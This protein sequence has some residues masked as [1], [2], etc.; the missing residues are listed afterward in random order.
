[1][2]RR[3]GLDATT[4]QV[5]EALRERGVRAL[6]FKGPVL[7][8]W[9][10]PDDGRVYGDIDLLASP[11]SFRRAEGALAELGFQMRFAGAR[12]GERLPYERAWGRGSFDVDL[13]RSVWGVG[14]PAE[15]AWAVLSERTAWLEIAGARVEVPS[16]AVQ[17]FL[18]ALHAAQHGRGARKP[19]ED[20]R[21][22]LDIADESVWWE[23]A[24]VARRLGSSAVFA[25]GLGLVPAG[26]ELAGRLG[27]QRN[28]SVEVHLCSEGAPPV[29]RGFLRFAAAPSLRARLALLMTEL[30]PSPPAMRS[31]SELARRGR[32][33]LFTAYLLRPFSLCAQTPAAWRAVR[34]ARRRARAA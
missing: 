3:L 8:R 11:A 32:I 28:A 2:T 10:Y 9:I 6:L 1:V 24:E 30:L 17:A 29:S 34:D 12:A 4:A 18:V 14:A 27:L 7:E 5:V 25:V 33:G 31:T 22:A 15:T 26:E 19:L 16:E 21:R 20:L 23:A 13:H